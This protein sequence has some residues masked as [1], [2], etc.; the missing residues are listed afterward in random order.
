M[1]KVKLF[2]FKQ[3]FQ[4]VLLI[5]A[6]S[7]ANIS[8]S[9]SW[10]APSPQEDSPYT[11]IDFLEEI[12]GSLDRPFQFEQASAEPQNPKLDSY[13]TELV[14]V[15]SRSPQRTPAF[16]E[17][18]S[19]RIYEGKIQVHIVTDELLLDNTLEVIEQ[20]GGEVTI[21]S[22]DKT[23][24]QAWLPFTAI[25]PLTYEENI[26]YIQRPD[27]PYPD[28]ITSLNI[29]QVGNSLTEGLQAMNGNIWHSSGFQGQG[30]KIAIVDTGFEGYPNLLGTDLPT[31]ISVKNF[32]E[33]ESDAQVN[34]GGVHGTACAE[35]VYD[36]SPQ[37][38]LYLVKFDTFLD[39][40]EAIDWVI[41]QNIDIVSTSFSF[42]NISSGDGTGIFSDLIQKARDAGILWIKSSGNYRERHWG[43]Q[44]TPSN[45]PE[46]HLWGGTSNINVFTSGGRNLIISS[47]NRLKGYLRWDDWTTVNQDY[48]LWLFSNDGSGWKPVASSNKPQ[49]GSP[50]QKPTESI[51]YTTQGSP[52]IYGFLIERK[53]ATRNVNL[54]FITPVGDV[55]FFVPA[56]SLGGGADAPAA[57]TVGAQDFTTPYL[58]HDYSSEGPTNGPGGTATGGFIKPDISAYA[59]VTTQSYDKPFDGTSASAPHVAG[60]AALVLSAHPDYGPDQIQ[61]FLEDRAIDMGSPG[62]DN[63]YGYGRLYLGEPP[64]S[65]EMTLTVNKAGNGFGTVT[66][67][68][69]GIDCGSNCSATF[70]PDTQVTLT[71]APWAE[72]TFSGW[73][74][75]CSG[76]SP[77]CVVTMNQSLNVTATF[78]STAPTTFSD[79][80]A[81]HWAYSWIDRLY[82]AGITSGCGTNPLR[83]CPEN[84]VTRAEMAKFL[85]K[86]IY[87]Q[88][89]NPAPL[90]QGESTGFSDVPWNHWAAAWIKQ[91]AINGITSGCG[92]G[93]YCPEQKVTRAE[94]AKFLLTAKYGPEYTP[95]EIGL[96]E[97]T[98]FS[99]V[100][101]DYWA[102]AWIKQ[103][104]LEDITS[105][106]LDG[107]YGPENFVTRAEMAKFLAITFNLPEI[108]PPNEPE[109]VTILS[110]HTAYVD[111]IDYL[112]IIGE[113]NNN[114]NDNLRFVEINVNIFDNS[115]LLLDTDFTFTLLD[116]LPA[117]EKTCFHLSLQEPEGWDYYE[118]E[119]VSFWTDGESLSNLSVSNV[120]S[121]YDSYFGWYEILGQVTNNLG[122]KVN[123]VSP[124]GTLY[125]NS[126]QVVGCDFTYVNSTDL[127]PG[128]TSSFEMSFLGRDYNDVTSYK[129]QVDGE[130][131]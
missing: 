29:D 20:F 64:S 3:V 14:A 117:R 56:R 2:K 42:H 1:D 40:Q 35:I 72:S 118:F 66:S 51:S 127:L 114:T 39:L 74:G 10:A 53:N 6:L 95:P 15:A 62:K 98:G 83:Y 71:A 30:V 115:G 16:A 123:W 78:T 73:S 46:Y 105:G 47:D 93:I 69:P 60:A 77:T 89:Y 49:N 23:L 37:A 103:L 107:T 122:S 90:Q 70:T 55:E 120:S 52:A 27:I 125:N 88:S 57:L 81:N 101:N 28:E 25:E 113:V 22:H 9:Q 84:Q 67:N 86:G 131:E 50:G 80:P 130:F 45:V 121:S 97:A 5:F 8:G 85:L 92:P 24:L 128:Q 7:F 59:G 75:A 13:I 48:D 112:N 68:P 31:S 99:D 124:I 32:V 43:G 129:I 19:L 76:T 119:P 44:F 18:N 109:G 106:F 104:Y 21:V 54:E 26:Y 38:Q 65:G 111:N 58:Q 63:A 102:A 108:E 36:I 34:G 12:P 116:N 61:S 110:N 17:E 11:K 126:G 79:V 82:S 100:P 41:S 96:G 87:G 4:W 91:L 94:M 33:G